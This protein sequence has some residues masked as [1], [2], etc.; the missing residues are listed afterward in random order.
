MIKLHLLGLLSRSDCQSKDTT[1]FFELNSLIQPTDLSEV[2]QPFSL[3]EIE[4]L[5]NELPINKAPG[6]DA[7]N[8]MFIKKC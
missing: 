5:I 6:P 4:S 3:G 8:G 1:M 2:D 7:F